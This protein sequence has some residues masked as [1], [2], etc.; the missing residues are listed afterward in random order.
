[1][2]DTLYQKLNLTK[3]EAK[4]VKPEVAEKKRKVKQAKEKEERKQQIKLSQIK[5]ADILHTDAVGG[6]EKLTLG[7]LF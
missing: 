7:D 1:M 5:E 6:S 2:R 4:A 3:P